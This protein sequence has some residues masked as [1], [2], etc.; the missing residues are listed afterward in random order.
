MQH[1]R[2][3]EQVN[4]ELTET[5]TQVTTGISAKAGPHQFKVNSCTLIADGAASQS[6]YCQVLQSS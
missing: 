4:E 1:R 2:G 3:T 5:A 6:K